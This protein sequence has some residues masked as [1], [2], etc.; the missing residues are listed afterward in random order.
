MVLPLKIFDSQCPC[1]ISEYFRFDDMNTRKDRRA[2]D[3]LAP[4]RKY[5]EAFAENCQQN[6]S[7]RK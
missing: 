6:F 5:F 2:V 1:N 7:L 3:K 4:I